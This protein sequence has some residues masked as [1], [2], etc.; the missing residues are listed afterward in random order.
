MWLPVAGG[1]SLGSYIAQA[2]A[3]SIHDRVIFDI[4]CEIIC[5]YTCLSLSIRFEIQ[6]F[7]LKRK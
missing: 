5:D 3:H 6:L 4:G 1:A 2:F 7:K